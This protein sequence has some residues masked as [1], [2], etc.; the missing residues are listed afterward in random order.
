MQSEF[1]EQRDGGYYIAGV[2]ISLDSIVYAF[3]RGDSPERILEEFPAIGKLSRIYGAIG[4]YLD[5]KAE[6]DKHLEETEREFEAAGIPMAE[7]NPELWERLQRAR[8][9]MFESHS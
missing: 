7:E 6:I 2:R 3:N 1:I 5:H 9:R 4:F 8:A